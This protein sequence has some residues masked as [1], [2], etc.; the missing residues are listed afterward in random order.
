MSFKMYFKVELISLRYNYLKETNEFSKSKVSYHWTVQICRLNASGTSTY[1]R[2]GFTEMYS[3]FSLLQW[4]CRFPVPDIVS[5]W[6]ETRVIDYK[7]FL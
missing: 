7:Y 2:D 3:V 6:H 5:P 1:L 4:Q